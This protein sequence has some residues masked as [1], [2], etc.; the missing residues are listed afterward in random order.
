MP[1]LSI[2]TTGRLAGGTR[3]LP[4][5]AVT[6]SAMRFCFVH[7]A[8]LHLD[9]PF[10]GLGQLNP[11]LGERLRDASLDAFDDLVRLAIGASY[12]ARELT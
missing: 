9:T 6:R 2:G 1:S 3:P 8:D 10:E 5:L 12:H 4:T 11:Q 7:A